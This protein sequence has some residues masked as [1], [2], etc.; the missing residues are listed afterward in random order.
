MRD[1]LDAVLAGKPVV[2]PVTEPI[3]CFIVPASQR[4]H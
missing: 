3:G 1:A 4:S 2:K